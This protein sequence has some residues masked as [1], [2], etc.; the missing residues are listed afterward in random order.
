MKNSLVAEL[1]GLEH[2]LRLDANNLLI[3]G[4]PG[5]GKT[6]LALQLLSLF[7]KE[8]SFY[9]SSRV[10]REKLA[11]QIA[12]VSEVVSG[13]DKG[14]SD[15]RL[16]DADSFLQVL[17][18]T[19]RRHKSKTLAIALDTWDSIAKE[20]DPKE[21]L[22]AEK[23]LVAI[24]DNS[25]A[26]LIFVS[27]EPGSTTIDYLVDGVVELTRKEENDRVFREIE[28]QKLRG[29]PIVQHKYLFTLLGGQFE[30]LKSYSS[31]NYSVIKPFRAIRD[32]SEGYSFGSTWIDSVF[33]GMQKSGTFTLEYDEN[34]P[35]SII[36]TI[37][38]PSIVNFLLLGRSVFLI[39]LPGASSQNLISLIENAVGNKKADSNFADR[40]RI[41]RVEDAEA[42]GPSSVLQKETVEEQ[43]H[44]IR[45][46]IEELREK[47]KDRSVLLVQCLSLMENKFASELDALLEAISNAVSRI[48][49]SNDAMILFLQKDSSMRN[50]VLAMSYDFASLGVK[51][52]TTILLGQ[53]RNTGVFA[54]QHSPQ[55]QLL[56]ELRQIL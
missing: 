37:E 28:V 30:Y 52:R 47:S 24:G 6:T 8:R 15:L 7:G 41:L 1:D 13:D 2:F 16:A 34:V 54:I 36:R 5:T 26:T 32:S 18:D 48:Q 19:I 51:D 49:D 46:A 11:K 20:L 56:P 44:E 17:F 43:T 50:K 53:K 45:K 9:I 31:P 40:L 29:T 21:R 4:L 23:T 55:N 3:K 14:F 25:K 42:E 10:P 33:G 35:Y 22:K 12:W 39:P 27:E 38:L